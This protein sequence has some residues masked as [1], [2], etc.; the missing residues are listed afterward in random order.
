MGEFLGG[1]SRHNQRT[2][3]LLTT[4]PHKLKSH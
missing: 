3:K 4:T 1:T 2:E